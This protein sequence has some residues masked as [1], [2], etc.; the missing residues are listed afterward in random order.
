MQEPI[1]SQ[2]PSAPPLAPLAEP[3]LAKSLEAISP[4]TASDQL[5]N[6]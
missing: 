1:L 3:P 2:H 4:S 6:L 5:Q